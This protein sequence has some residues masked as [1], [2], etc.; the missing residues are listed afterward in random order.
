M[1]NNTT[2]SAEFERYEADS[3]LFSH[4]SSSIRMRAHMSQGDSAVPATKAAVEILAVI[5]K[6]LKSNPP[7]PPTWFFVGGKAKL[8]WSIGLIQKIFGWPS[9]AL[10][11]KKFGLTG[12]R[13]GPPINI[14][15]LGATATS[16]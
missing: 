5:R 16:S 14:I 2:A 7:S 6:A 8:F 3:S 11:S 12:A 10:L 4:W 15:P 13:K 1:A 9:N